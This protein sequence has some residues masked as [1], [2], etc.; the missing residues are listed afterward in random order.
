[1]SFL[2][3]DNLRFTWDIHY[4]CNYRCPYCWFA[5]RWE[6]LEKYNRYPPIEE[7]VKCWKN[8]YK[9]YSKAHIEISGGEPFLYPSF[10]ELISKLAEFHRVEVTTNLSMDINFYNIEIGNIKIHPSFHLIHS[11]FDKFLKRAI[12]LKK[13]KLVEEV[14]FLAWPPYIPKINY[15]KI[16]FSEQEINFFVQPYYGKYNGKEYPQEY[17]E[18][19]KAIIGSFIGT[20]GGEDYKPEP[21]KTKGKICAAG[22]RYGVIKPDGKVFR[23][24]GAEE[25]I[26][27]ILD[28]GFELREGP[29]PCISDECK[30]NEWAFLLEKDG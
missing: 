24:G 13:R 12:E 7:I 29:Y 17:T 28:D 15:Y 18:E 3:K 10:E 27:D 9:K 6:S 1:M 22:F 8:I 14:S 21:V 4:V 20:R 26:G 23:C 16:K 25:V 5:E 2:Q 30:C 11:D 19:E